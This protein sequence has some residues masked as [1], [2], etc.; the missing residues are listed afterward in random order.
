MLAEEFN[1]LLQG[2]PVADMENMDEGLIMWHVRQC[3]EYIKTSLTCCAD[4]TLEGQ[5]SDTDRPATDGFGAQ[6]VCRDF[7]RVFSWAETHRASDQAGY[8]HGT[9]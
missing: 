1:N 3:F 2:G 4:T 6:H 8:P 9:A 7:D 5:K